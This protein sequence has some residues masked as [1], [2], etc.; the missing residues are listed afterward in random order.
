MD[1]TKKKRK[2]VPKSLLVR[3]D[4]LGIGEAMLRKQGKVLISNNETE[5]SYTDKIDNRPDNE[6]KKTVL[7]IKDLYKKRKMNKYEEE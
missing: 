2:V 6:N 4:Y 3:E 5:K 1:L 7:Q